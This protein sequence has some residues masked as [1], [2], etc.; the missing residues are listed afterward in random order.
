M[1]LPDGPLLTGLLSNPHSVFLSRDPI[2]TDYYNWG[3]SRKPPEGKRRQPLGQDGS[4][5]MWRGEGRRRTCYRPPRWVG[6]K[7]AGQHMQGMGTERREQ[8]TGQE[9]EVEPWVGA[10]EL[11]SHLGLGRHRWALMTDKPRPAWRM[12]E[13]L[14]M[15]T[16][17]LQIARP[18]GGGVDGGRAYGEEPGLWALGP[19]LTL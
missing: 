10:S 3:C 7:E 18:G 17:A 16:S 1:A 11:T 12:P 14:V 19:H 13:P 6:R 5:E 4:A 9:A 15:V 8:G 2:S